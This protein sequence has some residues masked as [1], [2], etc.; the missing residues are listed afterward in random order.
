MK[1]ELDD[2]LKIDMSWLKKQGLL[3]GL[4]YTSIV[5][6]NNVAQRKNS[7]GIYISV[8]E[9][10]RFIR[11]KYTQTDLYGNKND[12]DYKIDIIATE[13]NFGGERYWFICP[14]DGCGR[15]TRVLYKKENCFGCRY[16]QKLTY[17]SQNK[18]RRSKYFGLTH[19]FDLMH[20]VDELEGEAKKYH[21]QGKITKKR[22]QINNLYKKISI[23]NINI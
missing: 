9:A 11:L 7:I 14:L 6:E 22:K 10:S 15:K 17:K 5:W 12:F 13:C 18:N 2:L 19:Y 4:R 23:P 3:T 16:C 8:M 1:I 21:Y 20:K